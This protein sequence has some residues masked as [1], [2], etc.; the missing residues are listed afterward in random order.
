MKIFI[1]GASGYIGS[2]LINSW[3]SNPEIEKIIALDVKSPRFLWN[4]NNPKIHFIQKNL[5]DINIEEELKSFGSVDVVI[6]AAYFIRTPYFKKALIYQRYSNFDGAK[7]IFEFC[8]K[9]N[10]KKL[11]HFGTVASYGARLENSLDKKFRESDS[12]EEEA[13]AYGCD[14]KIIEENLSQFFEDHKPATDVVVLRLGSVSGPFLINTV[15]KIGLLSFF[16]GLSPFIP[17]TGELS[18]RQYIHEDDVVSAINFLIRKGSSQNEINIYNLAA[19][20]Y[21]T[22]REIASRLKKKTI[23]IPFS[24]A[25]LV[26]RIFWNLSCGLVPTPP[27]VINSYTFPIIVDNSKL[28]AAGF[29][30]KFNCQESLLG[31]A[32]KFANPL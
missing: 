30:Y 10:I 25:N 28:I 31:S 17:I 7:N 18:A 15:K 5:A 8:F 16:R 14:K 11:I 1:T 27:N 13:I 6:H 29:K 24:L 23:K 9:N 21:L 12:L 19:D 32:G 3:L 26:F 2:L 4:E 20:C 22:F